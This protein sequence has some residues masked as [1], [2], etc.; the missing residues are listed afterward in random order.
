[1]PNTVECFICDWPIFDGWVIENIIINIMK[2]RWSVLIRIFI[3]VRIEANNSIISFT[4][5]SEVSALI[6][7]QQISEFFQQQIQQQSKQPKSAELR[8][9]Q[10][11]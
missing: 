8:Q 6:N 5:P 11:Q 7:V 4:H 2:L 3:N 10:Q 1:M 9:Q